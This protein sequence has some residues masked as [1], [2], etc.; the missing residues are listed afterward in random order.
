VPAR[1][2]AA[3]RWADAYLL[4]PDE[5]GN[6]LRGEMAT[7]FDPAELVELTFALMRFQ[8]GSKLR[9]LFGLTPPIAPGTRS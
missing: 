6:G 5:V 7:Q 1:V 4:H 8:G 3:L 9:I 2:K